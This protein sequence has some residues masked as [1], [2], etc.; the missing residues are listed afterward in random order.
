MSA[1]DSAPSIMTNTGNGNASSSS[2]GAPGELL[3]AARER[4]G[5]SQDDIAAK[6]KL[7]PRQI[8]AIESGDWNSLPERTFT[9]GFMRSYARIVG[10]D[11]AVVGLDRSPSQPNVGGELKP[12]P[13]AIGEIAMEIERNS[14]PVLARWTV[15]LLLIAVLVAGIAYFQ[16]GELLGIGGAGTTKSAATKPP[17][18]TAP[19]QATAPTP[20]T[21]S[22]SVITTP[23][24]TVGGVAMPATPSIDAGTTA[25]T[26]TPTVAAPLL[27]AVAGEKRITITFR[28]KSWTEVR[29]KGDVIYSEASLPGT[30]EFNGAVPLSFIVGNASN[31]SLSIDGKPYDM[32]EI[33][34]NDVAR[35]R[36][37]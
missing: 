1:P 17:I 32:S 18:V 11:P 19:A 15:P 37:E 6:L 5:L 10:L 8:A 20:T 29:S 7:A 30:R 3:R 4:A 16:W 24:A 2:N 9:R 21:S 31:V 13:A 36:I 12:T 27:A 33:T 34:R 23:A 35:F 28:G 26:T 22:G 25:A 14:R